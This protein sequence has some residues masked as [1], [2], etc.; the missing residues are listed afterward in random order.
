MS[1][2][3]KEHEYKVK[4][5]EI[6]DSAR[7][8]I[9][10]K[11]FEQMSIQDILDDLEISKGAFYHYFGSKHALL[12]ALI[13]RTIDEGVALLQPIF[14]DPSLTAFEKFRHYF[15]TA[16]VWKTAQKDFLLNLMG[17]LYSD[18]NVL[19]RQKMFTAAMNKLKTWFDL[20][21][22]QGVR[23]GDFN[24]AYPQLVSG[25][26]FGLFQNLGEVLAVKILPTNSQPI[27]GQELVDT[28][29]AYTDAMERILGAPNGSLKFLDDETMRQWALPAKNNSNGAQE[30]KPNL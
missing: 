28:M 26:I 30:R 15:T 25:I 21:V 27:D 22:E 12:E 2:I 23:D 10:T 29:S 20:I 24:P 18:D 6:L 9:Y 17:V 16:A 13:E 3:V 5:N 8:F 1:R 19:F 4:R 11:G 7:R 14:E